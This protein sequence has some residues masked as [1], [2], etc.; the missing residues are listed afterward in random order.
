[1]DKSVEFGI[2]MNYENY[3][4]ITIFKPSSIYIYIIWSFKQ[5]QQRLDI[6]HQTCGLYRI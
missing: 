4:S 2:L 6:N 5:T 1:M 3:H